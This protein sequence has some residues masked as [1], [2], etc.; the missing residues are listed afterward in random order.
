MGT[1]R[2]AFR[3]IMYLV[4]RQHADTDA[5]ARTASIIYSTQRPARR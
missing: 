2:N 5:G 4:G 1:L 3:F